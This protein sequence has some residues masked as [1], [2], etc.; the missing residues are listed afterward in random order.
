MPF[1]YI[2]GWVSGREEYAIKDV[3]PNA[4]VDAGKFARPI[5]RTK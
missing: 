5:Q 1:K 2:Y 4:S 3:Q